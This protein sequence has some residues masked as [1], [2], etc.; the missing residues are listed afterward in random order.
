MK[1]SVNSNLK[2]AIK[3]LNKF[4]TRTLVVLNNNDKVVGT[5]SDGNIRRSILEGSNLST[6]IDDIYNKRPIMIYEE[7]ANQQ[8]LKKIFFEKK[9][10]IIPIINKKKELKKIYLLEDII[11]QQEFSYVKNDK[12]K[13]LAV[14]IMAGGKGLRMRPYTN[15]FPKPLLPLGNE[16]VIDNIISKFLNFKMNNF[17]ITTNYKHKMINNHLSNYKSKINYKLIKEKKYLGTAGS[18]S[19]LKNVKEDLFFVTNCDVIIDESY[20]EIINFHKK[21]KNDLTIVAAKKKIKLSY[22][23][24]LVDNKNQFLKMEEKPNYSFLLN[25]GLYL[26]NRNQLKIL[27]KN[28]KLDMDELIFKFKNKKKKIGIFEIANNNWK[29]FGNW[30]SYD[31]YQ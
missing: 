5:L 7:E 29:D 8:T 2:Q 10:Q 27:K 3:I 21:N 25:I 14:V 1:I 28:H 23:V 18:L 12:F 17:Y 20:R 11:K 26:V 30:E 6:S 13:N 16:T 31:N 15:F 4:G 24:C 9:I 19:Y 22:G